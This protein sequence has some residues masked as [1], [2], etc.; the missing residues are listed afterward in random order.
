MSNDKDILRIERA[1][2]ES[3]REPKG[4]S[5]DQQLIADA[6]ESELYDISVQLSNGKGMTRLSCGCGHYVMSRLR[7]TVAE[8]LYPCVH[9]KKAMVVCE[10]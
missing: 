1:L 7:G 8:K 5:I 3:K 4:L 6:I 10:D 9:C 2:A